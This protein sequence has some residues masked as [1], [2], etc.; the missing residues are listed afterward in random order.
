MIGTRQSYVAVS[1]SKNI[2]WLDFNTGY[3]S[4]NLS[5]SKF[6][7]LVERKG[8]LEFANPGN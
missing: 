6:P 2:L 7:S 5:C 8:N 4:R 1:C 3:R